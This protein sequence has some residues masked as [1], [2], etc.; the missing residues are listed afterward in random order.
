MTEQ[1]NE[2]S[3]F[4]PGVVESRRVDEQAEPAAMPAKKAARRGSETRRMTVVKPIRC[5][6]GE[7]A[8]FEAAA[9]SAGLSVEDY[10]R[11]VAATEPGERGSAAH[12][13]RRSNVKYLR[14]TPEQVNKIEELAERAGLTFG[15]Y[16]RARGGK[17]A[18]TL[19]TRRPPVEKADLARLLGLL[20]NAASN[21]NQVARQLN[22]GANVPLLS[23]ELAL[24]E[25]QAAAAEIIH[26]LGRKPARSKAG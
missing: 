8:E 12:I 21:I 11:D 16:V 7:L 9:T 19:M 26:V 1:L 23:A 17:R 5:T 3:L 13:T 10:L 25:V 14:L 22:S 4:D 18:V 20:G 2:M 24:F 15:S 6:D